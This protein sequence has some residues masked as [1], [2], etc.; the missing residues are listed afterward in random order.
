M[1]G[2]EDAQICALKQPVNWLPVTPLMYGCELEKYRKVGAPVIVAGS[3][4][5]LVHLAG[6]SL[7]DPDRPVL[8][9][10]TLHDLASAGGFDPAMVGPDA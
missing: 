7:L 1:Q 5:S 4:E 2:S 8:Y 3:R 10:S 6:A 9:A